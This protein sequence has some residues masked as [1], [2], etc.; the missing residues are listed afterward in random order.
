MLLSHPSSAVG[1]IR[2]YQ[3]SNLGLPPE[4]Y[5]LDTL[6]SQPCCRFFKKG[7]QEA[8]WSP[9]I[10]AQALSPLKLATV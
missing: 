8:I 7:H 3:G 9:D 1:G 5:E 10:S 6:N 2:Q 4:M